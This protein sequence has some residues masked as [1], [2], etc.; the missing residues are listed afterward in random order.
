MKTLLTFLA[1]IGV[2]GSVSAQ[3]TVSFNNS[4]TFKAQGDRLVRDPG[5]TPLV[6]TQF[7]AQLYCGP[8]P[9]DLRP[10]TNAPARF[11]AP[12]TA[13]PGTWSGG[14]RTVPGYGAG[15]TLWLQVRVWNHAQFPTYEDAVAGG[16]V[17]AQ[18]C[19]FTYTIPGGGAPAPEEFWIENFP[20]IPGPMNC[21]SGWFFWGVSHD[22]LSR[23]RLVLA[24]GYA[25]I[26][27]AVDLAQPSWEAVI[28][29]ATPRILMTNSAG[30]FLIVRPRPPSGLPMDD[31]PPNGIEP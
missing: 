5:G 19:A 4:V 7:V 6:G 24:S 13:A 22:P 25:G 11:R 16:G 1:I 20:G 2:T 31:P 15:D 14:T 28:S 30:F 3:G 8:S 17:R 12:T 23:G 10:V 27:Q 26:W 9:D 29:P 18:S 21:E